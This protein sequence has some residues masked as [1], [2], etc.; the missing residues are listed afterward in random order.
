MSLLTRPFS[1]VRPTL[2]A[3][4]CVGGLACGEIGERA[5]T[6]PSTLAL[7]LPA[8]LGDAER[9]VVLFDHGKH[10]D[11]LAEQGCGEC[12]PTAK[13]GE[14]VFKFK[15]TNEPSTRTGVEDRFHDACITCHQTRR[16][17]GQKAG[18]VTCGECHVSR[19]A[20]SSTRVILH[21]DYSL[22]AR[23][24]KAAE[25]KC[26]TCHHVYN[27]A[28]KSLEYKKGAE[29]ACGDCH[30][31]TDVDK[32]PSLAHAAHAE[33]INCHAKR[34]KTSAKAGPV[35]CVGCH[36]A[37]KLN[38]IQRL[39]EPPRLMRGQPDRT[40]VHMGDSAA[41][42]RFARVPFDHKRHEPAASSCATCHHKTLES[43]ATCHDP[44]GQAK[45]G[46]V[47]LEGAFH[48]PA[49]ERSCVGCHDQRASAKP[50]AGCHRE[51]HATA[52]EGACAVCH[53]GPLALV[54]E[55]VSPFEDRE[56]VLASLPP[57]SAD[58]PEVVTIDGLAKKYGPAKLPHGKIVQALDKA[59]RQIPLATAFHGKPDTLCAGCHHHTPAGAR[60]PPCR[61]CHALAGSEQTD[62]P[63][64][65]AA[66][67]RQCMACH[68]RLQKPLGC[69][70]CHE[71]DRGEAKP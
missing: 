25:D 68:E 41:K 30:G 49:S 71:R 21:F 1:C 18:P 12:H 45:G 11:A 62:Q 56:V 27:E 65:R 31:E 42:T 38:A 34:V 28:A 66:Y 17:K 6:T 35:L 69:T 10:T 13:S 24:A 3:L 60:P 20:A 67:H 61:S 8:T 43:C 2:S 52:A 53:K 54:D 55:K 44:M 64:L 32:N 39:A 14:Y 59:A 70:G 9:P 4:L 5:R 7:S 22:H 26:E 15:E 23:H 47:T 50:C 48:A 40:W 29:S 63:G 33:C 37:A 58:F 36:D 19:T 51:P 46:G 16:D 57:F